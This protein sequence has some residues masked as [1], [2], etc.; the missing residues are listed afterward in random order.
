MT[1][2]R[3]DW[4]VVLF[5]LCQFDFVFLQ[6]VQCLQFV[7]VVSHV[8]YII[9]VIWLCLLLESCAV[10]RQAPGFYRSASEMKVMAVL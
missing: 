1:A 9:Y 3:F 7:R 6:F 10:T 8:C 2:A 4:N 5:F